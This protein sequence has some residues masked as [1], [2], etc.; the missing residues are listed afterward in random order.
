MVVHAPLQGLQANMCRADGEVWWL[1]FPMAT[2]QFCI[3]A[4]AHGLRLN[5]QIAL[6]CRALGLGWASH[7]NPVLLLFPPTPP[8]EN[9]FDPVKERWGPSDTLLWTPAKASLPAV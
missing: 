3:K 6:L 8:P 2:A 7:H 1:L 5:T 4:G 9:C